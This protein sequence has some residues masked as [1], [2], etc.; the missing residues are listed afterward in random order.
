MVLPVGALLA[1]PRHRE[2]GHEFVELSPERLHIRDHTEALET[3]NILYGREL[4]MGDDRAAIRATVDLVGK[5]ERIERRAD[6]RIT[7]RVDVDLEPL[8]V[9]RANRFG[10]VLRFPNQHAVVVQAGTVRLEQGA[11]LI[12]DHAIGKKLHT[13]GGKQRIPEF[14]NAG[15]GLKHPR[16]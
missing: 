1:E 7:D 8:R 4:H 10:Q 9:D 14:L 5:V 15:S 13:V 11:G 2:H 6:R 12:F 3:R 16:Q